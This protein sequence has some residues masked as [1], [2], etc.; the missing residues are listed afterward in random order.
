MPLIASGLVAAAV[1]GSATAQASSLGDLDFYVSG[2]VGAGFLDDARFSGTV[3][4]PGGDQNVDTDFDD[5][6]NFG[7][8]LGV[9]FGGLLAEGVGTRVEVEVSYQENDADDLDFSGNGAGNE[10][11]VGG[12]ISRLLVM[13]NVFLDFSTGSPFKPYIGGGLGVAFADFDIVYGGA[14]GGPPP[15]RFDDTDTNFAAQA[16]AGASF[17]VNEQISF[18]VDGRYTVIFDVDGDRFNNGAFTGNIEEDDLDGY[19]LNAGLRVG[20]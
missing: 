3:T 5:S 13:G 11:N 16:I 1:S 18:F 9:N 8:S 20:F 2:F 6:F 12:D 10:N 4:P 15:V 14:A 19:S 7:G 17:A